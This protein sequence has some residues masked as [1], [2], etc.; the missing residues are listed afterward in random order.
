MQNIGFRCRQAQALSPIGCS[1]NL[2]KCIA[3]V[4]PTNYHSKWHILVASLPKKEAKK[5][6]QTLN[7]L[8]TRLLPFY[9]SPLT[10][11]C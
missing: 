2:H 4:V 6:T 8:F 3:V 9:Y 10:N 1:L 7:K 5:L 11:L